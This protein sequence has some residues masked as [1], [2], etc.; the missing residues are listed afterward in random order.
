MPSTAIAAYLR[1]LPEH[2]A[3]LRLMLSDAAS[4]PHMEKS[5]RR[6]VLDRWQRQAHGG[7][8]PAARP[9]PLALARM[10]IGVKRVAA[11]SG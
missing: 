4:V 1:R 5:A 9:T 6:R 10:G 3:Q 8:L 2:Q 7:R 11:K